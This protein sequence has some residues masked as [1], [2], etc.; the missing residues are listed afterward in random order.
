MVN[1]MK[2]K[3]MT[4]PSN[5]PSKVLVFYGPRTRKD[6]ALNALP[7]KVITRWTATAKKSVLDAIRQEALTVTDACTMY[8]LTADELESWDR[9]EQMY[10]RNGL[11]A[12]Q[13]SRYRRASHHK[14]TQAVPPCHPEVDTV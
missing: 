3:T 14:S 6:A 11:M 7:S 8:G 10:G 2:V 4:Q 12:T 9:R 1:E 13:V 5:H